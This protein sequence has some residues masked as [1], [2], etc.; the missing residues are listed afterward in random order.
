M[1]EWRAIRS[2][3]NIHYKKWRKWA[4]HPEALDCPWLLVEGVA[5][6]SDIAASCSPALLLAVEGKQ[7]LLD[8]ISAKEGAVLLPE[9]LFARLSQVQTSP[10]VA[11]FF[12]K[13]AWTWDDVGDYVLYLDG[14]RNPGNLG[15]LIRTAAATGVFSVVIGPDSVSSF[16][17][18][19]VRSTAAALFR[20]PVLQGVELDDVQKRGYQCWVGE[21]GQGVSLFEA[22]FGPPLALVLGGESAGVRQ[23]G[24]DSRLVHIPMAAG[25]ESLNVSV[26]GSLMLYEVVRRT[27]EQS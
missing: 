25:M 26:A 17:A 6:V 8:G 23:A 24:G 18:K 2:P 15:T 27:E 5:H 16:K 10:G 11:A 3:T 1:S 19:V 9:Q 14:V 21:A 20:V 22:D 12:P 7:S 13:P 4:G